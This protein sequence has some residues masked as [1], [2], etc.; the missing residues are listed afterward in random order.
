VTRVSNILDWEVAVQKMGQRRSTGTGFFTALGVAVLM[1]LPGGLLQ[2]QQTVNA[3]PVIADT[4]DTAAR[5]AI[6][7]ANVVPGTP[8]ASI[9]I[10]EALRAVATNTSLSATQK[11]QAASRIA[12]LLISQ[13]AGN[14]AARTQILNA[15]VTASTAA[16]QGTSPNTTGVTAANLAAALSAGVGQAVV[17]LSAT[18]NTAAAQAVATTLPPSLNNVQF[19][20]GIAQGVI[21]VANS[22][23]ANSTSLA[24]T[25]TA[26]TTIATSAPA[27]QTAVTTG[28]GEA[29]AVLQS[30][31]A[32]A[33][34]AT[35]V[36]TTVST[37]APALATQVQTAV[38]TSAT[39]TTT[40]GTQLVVAVT[41]GTCTGSPC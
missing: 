6:S 15:L 41:T 8:Q 20:A 24:T 33:A 40:T 3:L 21:A 34:A 19:Q 11:A 1:A 10:T 31:P 13:N 28:L 32:T 18:G 29:V 36:T 25:V 12:A 22:A 26:L 9:A 14:A 17:Q 5:S 16:L 39:T 4:V 23:P 30:N 2:A 37:T 38:V 7:N 35:T 27:L